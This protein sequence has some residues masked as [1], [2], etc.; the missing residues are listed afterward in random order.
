MTFINFSIFSRLLLFS[1]ACPAEVPCFAITI[2]CHVHVVYITIL[3][4]PFTYLVEHRHY[5][6]F[7]PRQHTVIGDVDIRRWFFSFKIQNDKKHIGK[8]YYLDIVPLSPFQYHLLEWLINSIY[9]F[10]SPKI[11]FLLY[12]H[13]VEEFIENK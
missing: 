3:S 1:F 7:V 2:T 5:L 12:L 11:L 4:V 10:L 6:L 8:P 13:Q 9:F